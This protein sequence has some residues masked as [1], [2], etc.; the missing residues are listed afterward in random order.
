MR[1]GLALCDAGG[2]K[3]IG[4]PLRSRAI[5]PL[6][7]GLEQMTQSLALEPSYRREPL[8]RLRRPVHNESQ[9]LM[10]DTQGDWVTALSGSTS[11]QN[12]E[13]DLAVGPSRAVLAGYDDGAA[14]L[15]V[16]LCF[17]KASPG[18]VNR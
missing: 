8:D 16:F 5:F 9:R 14:R 4:L 6:G 3:L 17:K 11:V 18:A 13:A 2:I 1:K 7:A 12:Q 15:H 10:V